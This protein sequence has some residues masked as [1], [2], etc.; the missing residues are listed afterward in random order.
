MHRIDSV[1]ARADMFGPG[2]SGYHRNEDLVGQDP[3]YLDPDHLNALQEEVASPIEFCDLALVKG[4]NTQLLMAMLAI[5]GQRAPTLINSSGAITR[6]QRGLV[7][8]DAS[9]GDV[10]LTLPLA[11]SAIEHVLWRV[12]NTA[13]RVLIMAAGADKILHNTHINPA[14]YGFIRLFGA[15]D[16]WQIRSNSAGQWL[17]MLRLDPAPIGRISI[18]TG[19]VV[20]SGGYLEAAGTLFTLLRAD[21]P[22][23]WDFAQAS[24]NIHDEVNWIGGARSGGYSRGDGFTTMRVPELR[25]EFIR[26]LDSARGVDAS[27]IFGAPQAGAIEAHSHSTTAV[28]AVNPAY[29]DGG[30]D[31]GQGPSNSGLTGGSETRPRNVAYPFLLKII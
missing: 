4:T 30:N 14:G 23:L 28:Q 17:P 3:T 13:N 9:A 24:G 15:G 31:Y 26:A 25:G 1:N 10:L 7:M 18:E 8:I 16:F 27:R 20:P 11:T 5:S 2:K 22:W 19:M 21:F 29:I 12:D 6:A